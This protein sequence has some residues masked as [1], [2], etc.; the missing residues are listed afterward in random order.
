MTKTP[1]LINHPPH[2]TQHESGVEVIEIARALPFALGSAVKYVMRRNLKGDPA[3]NLAKAKWMLD[4]YAANPVV[5]WVPTIETVE[6][7]RVVM[8]AEPNM[9]VARFLRWVI[10]GRMDPCLSYLPQIADR[11]ANM[12]IVS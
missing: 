4:D 8:D 11:D 9:A 7:V 5:G 1:D 6:L 3:E 2:Y 10:Y 12:G